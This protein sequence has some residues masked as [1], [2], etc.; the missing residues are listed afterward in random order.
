[1]PVHPHLL[2]TNPQEPPPLATPSSDRRYAQET[3]SSRLA[4]SS[5]PAKP[6]IPTR[7]EALEALRDL[8]KKKMQ[9]FNHVPKTCRIEISKTTCTALERIV[10]DP[11]SAHSWCTL[12]SILKL[13]LSQLMRWMEPPKTN[14]QTGKGSNTAF[15]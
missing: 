10:E 14:L 2:H 15:Q 5:S 3:P 11:S 1:M 12:L 9:T 4:S 8:L 6:A 7:T 13:V